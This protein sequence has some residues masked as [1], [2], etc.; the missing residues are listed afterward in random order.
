MRTWKSRSRDSSLPAGSSTF[1]RVSAVSMSVT[2]KF[3]AVKA[4]RSIHT[5]ID[6]PPEP[7]MLICD[8]PG[9]VAKR[10]SRY[11]SM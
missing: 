7:K 11:R 2:V 10:S 4:V 1:S 9:I 6:G 3:R 8:T 5:R